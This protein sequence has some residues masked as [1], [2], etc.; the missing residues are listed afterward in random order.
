MLG[1]LLLSVAP[2]GSWGA[3]CVLPSSPGHKDFKKVLKTL[4]FGTRGLLFVVLYVRRI[5][6]FFLI[7]N[8]QC[9]NTSLNNYWPFIDILFRNM[10]I[11][12]TDPW[13][14]YIRMYSAPKL[15][16]LPLMQYFCCTFQTISHRHKFFFCRWY[17]KTSS[18]LING[19]EQLHTAGLGRAAWR[20]PRY[21]LPYIRFYLLLSLQYEELGK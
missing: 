4:S 19:N 6:F 7:L 20:I 15:Q 9:W 3:V 21:F 12:G 16:W 10:P 1:S 8:D 17:E 13:C 11:Y 14:R 2:I 5:F 18:D